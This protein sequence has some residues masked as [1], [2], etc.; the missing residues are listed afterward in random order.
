MINDIW[1]GYCLYLSKEKFGS[2]RKNIEEGVSQSSE[3]CQMIGG[4]IITNAD[5]INL[6]Y[7]HNSLHQFLW[8]MYHTI[9]PIMKKQ[10]L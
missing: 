1:Y 7:D 9:Y 2:H 3:M 10:E 4:F 8:Y 5:N 6:D